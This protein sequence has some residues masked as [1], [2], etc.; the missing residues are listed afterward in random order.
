MTA[1]Y[2]L[3][4]LEAALAARLVA[5]DATP[6][7]QDSSRAEAWVESAVPLS[8]Q[9]DSALAQHLAFSVSVEDAPVINDATL[10]EGYVTVAAQVKVAWYYRIRTDDQVRDQRLALA[11]ARQVLGAILAPS[12]LWEAAPLNAYRPGSIVNEWMPVEQRYTV[13]LDVSVPPY[14]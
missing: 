13:I 1:P 12:P 2:T 11:A 8:A 5:L 14:P 9:E 3:E 6:W 4:E 7:V 10:P